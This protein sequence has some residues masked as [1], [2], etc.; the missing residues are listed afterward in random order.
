MK[1][2]R[3]NL[4]DWGVELYSDVGACWEG[5]RGFSSMKEALYRKGRFFSQNYLY[6]VVLGEVKSRRGRG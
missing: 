5:G 4:E 3:V 1:V 6:S 2:A